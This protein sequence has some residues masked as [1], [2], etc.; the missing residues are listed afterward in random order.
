MTKN[1]ETPS[2]ELLKETPTNLH[3]ITQNTQK[4]P[5]FSPTRNCKQPASIAATPTP[6]E[7]QKQSLN[8]PEKIHHFSS[9]KTEQKKYKKA[10]S[11][12]TYPKPHK[13]T[14]KH[15]QDPIQQPFSNQPKSLKRETFSLAQKHRKLHPFSIK[16]KRSP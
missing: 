14:T 7:L 10:S 3:C 1:H 9:P 6:L 5:S 15:I 16:P 4:N 12:F 11:F 2:H 8:N 13:V